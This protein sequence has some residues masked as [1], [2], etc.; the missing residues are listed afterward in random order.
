MAQVEQPVFDTMSGGCEMEGEM[1]GLSIDVPQQGIAFH[2]PPSSPH[3]SSP[4]LT[5]PHFSSLLLTPPHFSSLLLTPLTS[6]HFRSPHFSSLRFTLVA[7]T[8]LNSNSCLISDSSPRAETF[9]YIL[10]VLKL[11]SL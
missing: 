9:I 8:P 1:E 11:L 10:K 7:A 3:P 4:L 2:T 5:S 6:P